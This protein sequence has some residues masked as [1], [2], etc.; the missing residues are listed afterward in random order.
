MRTDVLVRCMYHATVS[1]AGR[2]YVSCSCVNC[3]CVMCSH[4]P[5]SFDTIRQKNIC[6]AIWAYGT[7]SHENKGHGIRS[8]R[9]DEEMF[10]LLINADFGVAKL[11]LIYS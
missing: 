5:S 1:C 10:Y 8:G 2:W 6:H 11:F 7:M 4:S 9:F 3:S